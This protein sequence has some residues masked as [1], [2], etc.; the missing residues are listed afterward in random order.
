MEFAAGAR[1]KYPV[2]KTGRDCVR[3][4]VFLPTRNLCLDPVCLRVPLYAPAQACRSHV[5]RPRV[6]EEKPGY[7]S[8]RPFVSPFVAQTGK[9]SNGEPA[10]ESSGWRSR[11]LV[12]E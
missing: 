4:L 7:P 1:E 12:R 5:Q 11:R 9:G 10:W 3:A 6:R 2:S 8:P